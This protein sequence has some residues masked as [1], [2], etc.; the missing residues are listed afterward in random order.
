MSYIKIPCTQCKMALVDPL[1]QYCNCC[2]CEECSKI[3]IKS[4]TIKLCAKCG[5]LA[6]CCLILQLGEL[7]SPDKYYHYKCAP[8]CQLHHKEIAS[9]RC[10]ICYQYYCV[11]C[12][13]YGY[14]NSCTSPCEC[15]SGL[16]AN[17]K[18]HSI[19]NPLMV[20]EQCNICGCCGKRKK[21]KYISCE[22]EGISKCIDCHSCKLCEHSPYRH[23]A[24]ISILLTCMK[25]I[26]MPKPIQA[27]IVKY[28]FMIEPII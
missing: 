19:N 24:E 8:K 4:Y 5:E 10:F 15:K 13:K 21:Q 25:I 12:V 1:V 11:D 18:L 2:K 22:S 3:N 23:E 14:C 26:R 28:Y 6:F 16:R 17:I 20:C 7:D 9:N 27:I